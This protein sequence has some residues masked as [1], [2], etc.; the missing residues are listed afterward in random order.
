M[1][2]SAAWVKVMGRK[3][4][5]SLFCIWLILG[6]FLLATAYA[7]SNEI[8]ARMRARVPAIGALKAQGI[9]GENNNGFL[10]FVGG[11][12]AKV[13]MVQAENNDRRAVYSAIARQQKTNPDL[14][15]KRRAKQIAAKA[16]PG[17]WLQDGGGRW[18]KK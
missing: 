6:S 16:R 3:R 12:K 8:K 10:E 1:K 15:G 4:L 17:S 18:Y 13:G 2:N 11:A 14:V 5:F 7:S 9:V